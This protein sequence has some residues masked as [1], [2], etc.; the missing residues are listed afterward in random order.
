MTE[1]RTSVPIEVTV[2]H[3]EDELVNLMQSYHLDL[4]NDDLR[5]RI[6]CGSIGLTTISAMECGRYNDNYRY[7]STC[8][9]R[10]LEAVRAFVEEE[11]RRVASGLKL[12][13][14]GKDKI[15]ACDI[16]I[17]IIDMELG[18]RTLQKEDKEEEWTEERIDR[19]L[20]EREGGRTAG[21][22][23]SPYTQEHYE[24]LYGIKKKKKD[25]RSALMNKSQMTRKTTKCKRFVKGL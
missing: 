13:R 11:K 20:N 15:E 10:E 16:V 8:T 6:R 5:F 21:R 17:S 24:E 2:F 19:I 18:E 22:G 14:S 25:A 7:L 3:R 9:T 1:N 12:V 4:S 23:D